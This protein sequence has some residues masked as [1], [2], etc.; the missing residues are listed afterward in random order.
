MG[1]AKHA[2][3]LA[4]FC[5]LKVEKDFSENGEEAFDFAMRQTLTLAGDTDTTCAIVGG[6]VG[7]FVG[8]A[9]MP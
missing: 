1:L 7:A 8:I 6:L 2:F 3:I 5:L 4:F 9:S